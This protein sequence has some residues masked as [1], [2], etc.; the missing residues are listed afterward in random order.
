MRGG[1][2]NGALCRDLEGRGDSL[3]GRFLIWASGWGASLIAMLSFGHC[4]AAKLG[5]WC[6]LTTE[7]QTTAE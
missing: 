4:L 1:N 7:L 5:R 6:L 2:G 3:R